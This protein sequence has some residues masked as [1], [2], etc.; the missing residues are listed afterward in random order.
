MQR[1]AAAAG[2]YASAEAVCPSFPCLSRMRIYVS[3]R[4]VEQGVHMRVQQFLGWVSISTGG[5]AGVFM[6]ASVLSVF[7]R[8][9][10]RPDD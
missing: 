1:G 7:G 5:T 3:G 2:T 10:C 8:A 4:Y 6:H 9:S